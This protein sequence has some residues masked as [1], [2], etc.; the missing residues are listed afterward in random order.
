MAYVKRIVCLANSYKPPHGR[1]VAGREILG[2]W[3]AGWIRPVSDRPA[4]E[5][6]L[7]EY[8]CD[9]GAI[10]KPLDIIDI[11]LQKHDPRHHQTENHVIAP[12]FWKKVGELARHDLYRLADYPGTLWINGSHT[13]GPGSNDCVDAMEAT[14]LTNSLVLLEPDDFHIEIGPNYWS[15]KKTFRAGFNH[16]RIHYNLSVTDPAVR[17]EYA[18]REDGFYPMDGVYICVSLTEPYE[19][20]DRCHKLVAAVIRN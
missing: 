11:P 12:G 6:S 13:R 19:Q 4:G 3:F 14:K 17:E 9:G 8:C 5:L 20:D 2:P 15:G 10:P 1:C 16:N 18:D 7:A